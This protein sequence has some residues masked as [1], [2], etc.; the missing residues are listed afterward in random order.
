MPL[1]SGQLDKL[2]ALG[3]SKARDAIARGAFGPSHEPTAMSAS[4][5]VAARD[6]EEAD[7]SAARRDAREEETL[8]IA[9]SARRI[10]I[11]AMIAAVAAAIAATSEAL[12]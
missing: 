3:P 12:K 2:V 5:W 10:A 8:A 7:R 9:R 11:A 4:A 6:K 1:N